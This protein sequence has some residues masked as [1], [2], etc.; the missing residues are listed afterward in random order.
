MTIRTPYMCTVDSIYCVYEIVESDATSDAYN[1]HILI[2][3]PSIDFWVANSS[4]IY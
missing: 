1:T 2:S 4:L 3:I